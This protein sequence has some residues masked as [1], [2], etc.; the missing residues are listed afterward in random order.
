MVVQGESS[1]TLPEGKLT[2]KHWADL[3]HDDDT[4][5]YSSAYA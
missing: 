1:I 5:M 3:T 2:V 4:G